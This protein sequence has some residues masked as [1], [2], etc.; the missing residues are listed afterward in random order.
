MMEKTASDRDRDTRVTAV[1]G[2]M[3]LLCT[4]FAVVILVAPGWS[5]EAIGYKFP[6][7]DAKLEFATVYG[8][9]YLGLGL[10][11]LLTFRRPAMREAGAALL[12]L[13]STGAV[14]VRG[15]GAAILGASAPLTLVV[16]GAEVLFTAVGWTAW[17]WSRR[18]IP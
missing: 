18:E 17:Y 2:G 15:A 5:A 11:W 8:G 1:L 14:V 12:A 4:A 16:F 3:G 10:F 6:H 9:F 7:A 13:T